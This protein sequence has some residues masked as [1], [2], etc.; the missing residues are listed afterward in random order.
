VLTTTFYLKPD[1]TSPVVLVL[2][3]KTVYY[4]PV[5]SKSS[6]RG[7]MITFDTIFH[8]LRPK[9]KVEEKIF[10]TPTGIKFICPNYES[11]ELYSDSAKDIE[12]WE[13]ELKNFMNQFNFHDLFKAEKRLGKGNFATVYLGVSLRDQK[14]VAIKAFGKEATFSQENGKEALINEIK[15]TKMFNHPNLMKL[16]GVYESENS[17]YFALEYVEGN[18]ICGRFNN[19]SKYSVNERKFI[20]KGILRGLAEMARK[21]VIHRDLKPDNVILSKEPII[22]DFG[23][24]TVADDPNYLFVRCGT[25]GYVAPEIINIKDMSSKSHPISDVFSVGCIFYYIIF[26]KHLFMG[27]NAQEIIAMNRECDIVLTGPEFDKLNQK[28]TLLV[29]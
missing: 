20:M 3:P 29:T 24:A 6:K 2:T 26:S 19:L 11:Q 23:L 25:P 21:N 22:I 18:P 16:E 14:K 15:I 13:L 17:I 27:K 28:G 7:F 1:N 8:V 5:D 10:G 4:H 12:K 9:Y